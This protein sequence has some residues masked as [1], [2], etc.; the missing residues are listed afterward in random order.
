MANT[1]NLIS[2]YVPLLDEKYARSII[3][4]D[5][6]GNQSLIREAMDAKSIL[7]PKIS[8]Q[9]LAN[10]S[11]STGFVA[12][13]ASLT[14]QTHTFTQDRGRSFIIDNADNMETA[15]VAFGALAA[16][17]IQQ[18]VAPE[19]DAYRFAKLFANKGNTTVSADLAA[20]T[21]D[22][23]ITQA[24]REMDDKNVPEEGRILYVSAE[25]YK[26]IKDSSKYDSMVGP[27]GKGRLETYDGMTLRRVPRTRFYTQITLLDGTTSGQEAGGYTKTASTGRDINFLI[28]HP[29]AVLS[30]VKINAPRVFTPEVNQDA[31]AYKFQLRL[32]H[33]C[34]IF[35]NK[36]D[37]IYAHNKTT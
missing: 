12:G 28:V 10:Y 36:V 26:L 6:I 19:V 14:W 27:E 2:K 22:A 16:D 32:Y 24:Q 30:P 7:V 11:R 4:N 34:F 8:T 5:L 13:D 31:D 25:I 17:F 29:T 15:E 20:S 9:A 3:T 35:E 33:D 23:A 21:V 37:G 18:R 1:I